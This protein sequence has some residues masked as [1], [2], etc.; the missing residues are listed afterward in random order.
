[1]AK[2]DYEVIMYKILKYLYECMKNDKETELEHFA[3]SSKMFSVPKNYWCEIIITLVEKGYITGFEI[4]KH[5]K[6]RP[7]V[8]TERPF[9]ITFE[10]VQFLNENSGMQKV[11]E[12]C[13]ETFKVLLSALIGVVI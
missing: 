5:T 6:D 11:R 10:G 3:W 12:Y 4:I 8:Q 7:Q 2:D 9:K 1:M 13:E